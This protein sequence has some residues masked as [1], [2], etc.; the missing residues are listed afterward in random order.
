MGL[1]CRYGRYAYVGSGYERPIL[2]IIGGEDR[3]I[4]PFVDGT[5]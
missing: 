3:G 2:L 4:P 5:M 1:R